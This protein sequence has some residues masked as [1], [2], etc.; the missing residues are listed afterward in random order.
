MTA[1]VPDT[2]GSLARDRSLTASSAGAADPVAGPST[3]SQQDPADH[4]LEDMEEQAA[5]E[6]TTR[7]PRKRS[8]AEAKD[9]EVI[10]AKMQENI[11]INNRLLQH[12]MKQNE[13]PENHRTAFISHLGKYLEQASEPHFKELQLMFYDRIARQLRS[14]APAPPPPPPPAPR[15]QQPIMFSPGKT[16]SYYNLMPG[17]A[18][19][20]WSPFKPQQQQHPQQQTLSTPRPRSRESA[21]TLSTPR[22]R[23]RESADL[24]AFFPGLMDEWCGGTPGTSTRPEE[25]EEQ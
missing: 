13:T 15:Q 16:H 7:R 9:D 21:E 1:D 12:I 11:D 22:P 5:A 18:S 14:P 17:F 24:S 20:Q 23:S 8:S 4:V 6:A 3:S 19:P 25:E 2:L 10:L